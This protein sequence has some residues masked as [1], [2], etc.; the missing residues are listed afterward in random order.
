MHGTEQLAF[1]WWTNYATPTSSHCRKLKAGSK[2]TNMAKRKIAVQVTKT[3]NEKE[4]DT[5]FMN[6]LLP[7]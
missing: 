7:T 5:S 4:Y 3:E 1:P 2:K 6:Y